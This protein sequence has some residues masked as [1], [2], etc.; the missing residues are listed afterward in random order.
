M[1]RRPAPSWKV[2]SPQ[3]VGGFGGISA[4]AF[5]FARRLQSSINVPIGLV[6]AAVGGVPAESWTSPDALRKIKDFDPMLDEMARLRTK[7]GQEYGNFVM[8]WYDEFDQGQKP[9]SSW[10][11]PQLDDS[12][13]KTVHVP[14]GFAE[15]GVPDTPSLVYFRKEIVL[16][17]PVPAGGRLYLGMIER[18][19]TVYIN[20]QSAGGSSWVEN[21]RVYFM[22]PGMLKPGKNVITIRVLKVKPDGGFLAKPEELKLVFGDGKVIPMA[23]EWKGKVSVDAR[24][25]HALPLAYENWPIMPSVLYNGMLKPIAPLAITGAIWYQGEQN[26]ERAYQYRKV[27][28]TMIGDWRRLFGQGNFPFYIVSLPAYMARKAEPGT[29]TWSELREAQAMTART[30]PHTCLAVTID[31]GDA[32]NIHPTE[33]QPV[34]DRLAL[35]AMAEHYGQKVVF[36]G[37]TFKSVEHVPGAL[38]IHFDHTDGGL[39]VKGDKL[40]EFSVAG[41][42]QKWYWADAK[43]E[44][45][46]IVV[47]SKSVPNPK[48]VRYAWQ[49]NPVATLFNGAG[50]PAVPFRT[51]QWPGVTEGKK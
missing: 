50:L 10:A 49:S 15:L 34:G 40:G 30:V 20:G 1:G 37:P 12:A 9:G 24:P 32:D 44:G 3:T 2:V 38:K 48:Q 8:H 45:N 41:D 39:V 18:M 16:P 4:A 26:S 7:G 17:D 46:T 11:D 35:C 13:W 36:S 51:D 29:D 33:K 27:L 19:D 6:Q 22:R 43:I 14:G 21:P 23:G 25:P 28:P 5:Y 31:T 47:S 42:D